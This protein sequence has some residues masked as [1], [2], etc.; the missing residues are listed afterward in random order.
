MSDYLSKLESNIWKFTLFLI[1][2]KRIY[3]AILS[4]Y[5]LTIPD[6]TAQTIG[7]I[8][9]V[10]NLAGFLFEVPSGYISDKLGH[11]LTLVTSQVIL[12]TS[13]FLFFIAEDVSSLI[14]GAIF[15][16]VSHSFQ[17]GTSKAFMHDTLIALKRDD[18]YT[19]VMGKAHSIGF[20]IPVF[21]TALIPFSIEISYQTPFLLTLIFDLIGLWAVTS[22]VSPKHSD[23]HRKEVNE[24]KFTQVVKEGYRL[25]YFKYAV[26]ASLLG[27][28]LFSLSS[29]RA[30]YQEEV[31][32][33]VIW[34]G[35]L[36]GLG[37]VMASA[38]LI[39][40]G[41]I[42]DHF[43]NI[44]N[45]YRFQIILFFILIFLLGITI[46]PWAIAS[47]FI[48]INAFQWGLVEVSDGFIVDIIRHSKFKATLLS[49]KSQTKA[50]V[51]AFSGIILGT[52]IVMT[53]YQETFIYLAITFVVIMLPLFLFIQKKH[54]Y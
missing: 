2:R 35:V 27:G 40:S 53:S 41:Q 32:L 12:V 43:D 52:V 1:T 20:F 8:S 16:S 51:D 21:F 17:S 9:L 26:F 38:M 49:F 42:K 29:F 23:E 15:L 34:F 46:N 31:G 18:E 25:G 39:F 6:T 45:L 30:P 47:I 14:L 5:F 3:T 48:I 50:L 13:T 7:L 33:L 22:L 10:G 36:H 11:K 24:T 19:K 28:I 4:V 44:L 37:R 54:K